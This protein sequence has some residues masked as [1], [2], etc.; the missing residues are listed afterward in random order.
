[1]KTS[2]FLMNFNLTGMNFSS[3]T[4]LNLLNQK[5]NDQNQNI[6]KKS[7]TFGNQAFLSLSHRYTVPSV[8]SVRV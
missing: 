3:D 1:M 4:Y 5:C 2:I 8:G 7:F 6:K